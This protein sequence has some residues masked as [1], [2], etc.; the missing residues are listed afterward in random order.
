MYSA[1]EEGN[2]GKLH[3]SG[4]VA[5][6]LLSLRANPAL[7]LPCVQRKKLES[8]L[9]TGEV[10]ARGRWN[11]W[12]GETS[13][14]SPVKAMVEMRQMSPTAVGTEGSFPLEAQGEEGQLSLSSSCGDQQLHISGRCPK[15]K[16]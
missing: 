15:N 11:L 16:R 8:F 7:H 4:Q 5:G 9:L 3:G 2:T 13:K 1:C 14:E 12:L 6:T 10:H